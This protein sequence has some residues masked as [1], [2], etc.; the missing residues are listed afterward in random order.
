MMK[1]NKQNVHDMIQTGICLQC[2]KDAN[3]HQVWDGEEIF[4]C[5]DGHRTGLIRERKITKKKAA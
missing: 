3:F 1:T 2:G 5:S 4:I